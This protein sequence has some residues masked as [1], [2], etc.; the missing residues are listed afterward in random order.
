MGLIVATV[1][2][3]GVRRINIGESERCLRVGSGLVGR[4]CLTS[5][6]VVRLNVAG[7][8]CVMA[9]GGMDGGGVF[10]VCP[11]T[12]LELLP[13]MDEQ[14]DPQWGKSCA[15]LSKSY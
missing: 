1:S 10:G 6:G 8:P 14:P 13:N 3:T 9:G 15:T 7:D 5:G 12:R 11:E 2:S 4:L